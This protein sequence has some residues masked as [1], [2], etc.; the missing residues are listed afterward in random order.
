[1]IVELHFPQT[2][3]GEVQW[4]GWD[5]RSVQKCA[6]LSQLLL[7]FVWRRSPHARNNKLETTKRMLTR[8]WRF[9]HSLFLPVTRFKQQITR[10][11]WLTNLRAERSHTCPFVSVGTAD[12][13]V[14]SPLLVSKKS[15]PSYNLVEKR[16]PTT[17]LLS[18]RKASQAT[19]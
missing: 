13:S 14:T 11:D 19:T 10:V 17:K 4:L 15:Q 16:Q 6:K 2:H 7:H 9:F 1:M 5:S 8:G 3:P 18:T 12:V